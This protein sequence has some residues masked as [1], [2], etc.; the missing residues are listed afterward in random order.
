MTAQQPTEPDACE[1]LADLADRLALA[2]PRPRP[3]LVA[4]AREG[5]GIRTGVLGV[6]DLA[7]GGENTLLG[8]GF[9]RPLADGTGAQVRHFVG[10]ARAVTLVGSH[11]SR[12]VSERLRGDPR[13]T[14]D[15]Q[16]TELAQRFARQLLD[17]D[18]HATEAGDWIRRRLCRRGRDE[19]PADPTGPSTAHPPGRPQAP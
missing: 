19:T 17:G 15:G 12:W 4:L 13:E 14:P 5:G 18:L 10:V 1:A 6:W 7:R 11:V 2:D 16:L 8:F 9:R 3:F